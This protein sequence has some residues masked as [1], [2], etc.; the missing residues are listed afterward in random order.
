M[1]ISIPEQVINDGEQISEAR[2]YR[3][4]REHLFW[5]KD[6]EQAYRIGETAKS[7]CGVVK[8]FKQDARAADSAAR[9]LTEKRPKDSQIPENCVTCVDVYSR[10][11]WARL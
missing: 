10:K 6:M 11:M 8:R 2:R 9:R 7:L 1:T 4:D 3:K 5:V